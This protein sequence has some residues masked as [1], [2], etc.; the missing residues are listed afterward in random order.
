MNKQELASKIWASANE[1]RSKIEASEYKDYILGLIFYKFLSEREEN[2]LKKEGATPEEIKSIKENDDIAKY[3]QNN[4]GYFISYDNLFST[5][6]TKRAD[7]EIGNV[8][9]AL[10]AFDRLINPSYR[11]VFKDIFKTLQQGI[12]KLGS[13]A[14][15][16]SKAIRD[17]C[18]L[19]KDIP[20]SEKD[21][22]VL[23]FIYEYLISNFAANAGK[24]AGEF[25]TPHEVSL[26]MSEIIADY[27]KDRDQIKIY[28]PTSGSGSL[29]IN[30][31]E[32]ISKHMSKKDR[33]KYYAQEL[34]ENTYNL[35]RM[36]LIMRGILPDNIITR[37]GD[38][39]EEDWPFFDDDDKENTMNILTDLDAVVSNPP[40]SQKWNV[41]N[42]KND[43]R[44]KDYGLAPASKADYAFLLHNLYHLGRDG[45]MT[46][47][48][49]HGVLF[50]GAFDKENPQDSQDECKIRYNLIENNNID[51]II[52]LPANIF[53]G[54][55]IP[56][57]IMVLKKDRPNDD[58]LFIDASK[59]F[60][61]EDKS[62]K[63]RARDIKKI[64]DT[65]N[66]RL[67]IPNYSRK[68]S[69]QEVRNNEYNLNIPRY[70]DSNERAESYSLNAIMLGG[71]PKDEVIEKCPELDVFKS[72][73]NELFKE[74]SSSLVS[75]KVNNISEIVKTNEDVKN[76]EKEFD[77]PLNKFKR[78]LSD[79]LINKRSEINVL[80]LKDCITNKLFEEF[81]DVPLLDK[82]ESYQI[83]DDAYRTISNDLEIITSE[84]N[85]SLKKVEAKTTYNKK[86]G[87]EVQNGYEGRIISFKLV[88]ENMFK[89]E[90]KKINEEENRLSSIDSEINEIFESISSEELD[91]T[92]KN[93][94]ATGFNFAEIGK[95]L[96][97]YLKENNLEESELIQSLYKA[98]KLNEESKSINKN[99]K[100]ER[101][102]IDK[103]TKSRIEN[104][105]DYEVNELLTIKWINPIINGIRNISTTTI[106][107]LIKKLNNLNKK[108]DETLG[109]LNDKI[110]ATENELSSM[111]NELTGSNEDLKG[112]D[113]LK[114]LLK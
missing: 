40:Y 26:L 41:E 98:Y 61:K 35:T 19:I 103:E 55:S 65:Y 44:F 101:A 107:N 4:L 45:I 76:Y 8:T 70:V 10:N 88:Q 96:K 37:C 5:W 47:V 29:L 69:K 18:D 73:Y 92:L 91:D 14:R 99:L 86:T 79:E 80:K 6:L 109:S 93:G 67:D 15:S 78:Y 52:G 48:L 39:L 60:I 16:Q 56:T 114:N 58:I 43:P 81:K 3:V 28:D 90:F 74:D 20:M 75:L 102:K 12:S 111:L 32:Q 72:L 82:Y 50:R 57:I 11:K 62:N 68:V 66:A 83:F 22:D 59:G 38:T 33:I 34:K 9:D 25:Y 53:F 104:L 1:M 84:G 85:E 31:G 23:G 113:A 77:E 110:R 21:Y 95:F 94:D 30:I 17:L 106:N 97:P 2:F 51:A 112:I 54:T 27:L 71:I 108:Y 13:D 63:L 7:F 24:K 100:V 36:N 42:K 46:I 105:T 49:P 64:V 89:E 87:T